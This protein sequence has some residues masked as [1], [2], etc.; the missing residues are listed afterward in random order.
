[1]TPLRHLAYWIG[2]YGMLVIAFLLVVVCV[3]GKLD[4]LEFMGA[5]IL[6][7]MAVTASG[8]IRR[9]FGRHYG[10]RRCTQ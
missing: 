9:G 10:E 1:M 2:E 6:I 7:C 8:Y 3:K 4:G 5:G